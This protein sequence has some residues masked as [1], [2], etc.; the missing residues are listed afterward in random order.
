MGLKLTILGC[1]SAK[2]TLQRFTTA[3]ILS[4]DNSNFL[5]DCGEGAQLKIRQF[6]VKKSK[7]DQIFIS[8]LHGDHF[9]G[10]PGII[11]SF[12][13]GGRERPLTIFGPVGLQ[14]FF[15]TLSEI[16]SFYLNF[17]VEIIELDHTIHQCIFE[18]DK[19]KVYAFPMKH[20]I[21]TTGFR[22]DEKDK[23]RKII[24]EYIEKFKLSIEE[25]K[26]LKKGENIKRV[27]GVLLDCKTLTL[28]V[29]TSS[30]AFCSDTLYDEDLLE[31]I[32]GVNVL[33]HEATYLHDLK[34]KARERM[35]ATALE[36]AQIA[37]KAKV[38]QLIIGHYSSRYTN[39]EPFRKEAQSIF[40][41]T[42]LADDGK[43]FDF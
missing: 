30:Y 13:L 28:E 40:Q 23:P 37:K 27:N 22:F 2:P 15:N 25:I 39:I 34:D 9:F 33:Y 6:K 20:R 10:L 36:A 14:N 19:I 35:H 7:I 3:Q 29:A 32:S 17:P 24:P 31:Y 43:E 8:H 38:G 5:I 41:N 42:E 16:G 21:P 26:R 1:N 18:D 4:T 12:N 11:T